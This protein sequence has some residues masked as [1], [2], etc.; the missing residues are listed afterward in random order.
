M[1]TTASLATRQPNEA[2]VSYKPAILKLD[3]ISTG[4]RK[5][6]LFGQLFQ[7]LE[8]CSV[9]VGVKLLD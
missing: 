8:P 3:Y 5:A 6:E 4:E 9:D 2:G 1:D 7:G